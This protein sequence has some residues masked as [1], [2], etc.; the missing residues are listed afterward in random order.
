MTTRRKHLVGKV[1][2]ES[3]E[4]MTRWESVVSI[5]T[6]RRR[7]EELFCFVERGGGM[8]KVIAGDGM[9]IEE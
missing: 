5:K 2:D 9:M 6:P 3:I 7:K 4:S 8:C 1:W